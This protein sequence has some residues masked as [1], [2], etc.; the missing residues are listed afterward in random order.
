M[1]VARYKYN[2]RINK[3]CVFCNNWIGD[4]N[5]KY[6]TSNNTYEFDSDAKGK[7]TKK[8]GAIQRASSC[9]SAHYEPNMDAKR[10]L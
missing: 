6:L 9:C 10:L 3:A 1:K 2:P 5:M 7:C 8:L 4:A